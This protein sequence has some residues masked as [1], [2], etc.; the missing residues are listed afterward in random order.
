MMTSMYPP[1]GGGNLEIVSDSIETTS[2]GGWEPDPNWSYIDAA[3]HVHTWK[4]KSFRWVKDDPN[5]PD[6]WTDADG[7][8]HNADT[9]AECKKCG[10]HIE[11]ATRWRPGDTFSTFIPGPVRYLLDGVEVTKEQAEAAI[12]R[13][14]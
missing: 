13:K 7:D 12:G 9:H 5:A 8:E 4:S 6:F 1:E 11:P 14:L 3:G 10:E 2:L